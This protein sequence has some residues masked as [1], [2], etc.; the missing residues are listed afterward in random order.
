MSDV[1]ENAWMIRGLLSGVIASMIKYR[2]FR[3]Q[4]LYDVVVLERTVGSEVVRKIMGGEA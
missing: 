1:T 2:C 4:P 3:K